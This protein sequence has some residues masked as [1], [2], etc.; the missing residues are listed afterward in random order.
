MQDPL[1]FQNT[2]GTKT[3]FGDI[4]DIQNEIEAFK[5]LD[6]VVGKVKSSV[7]EKSN[8]VKSEEDIVHN[9]VSSEIS[10]FE[11]LRDMIDNVSGSLHAFL[12][13]R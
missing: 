10:Y 4:A 6:D 9:T 12:A 3:Y 11:K 13:Q 8:P 5:K 1:L 2:V 7:D